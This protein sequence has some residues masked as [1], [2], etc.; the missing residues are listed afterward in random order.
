MTK[1]YRLFNACKDFSIIQLSNYRD[2]NYLAYA[3]FHRKGQC[4][5]LINNQDRELT[6]EVTVWEAGIRKEGVMTT[7]I[8]T[9]QE[10]YSL[11]A[12]EYP[13]QTGRIQIT[14]PAFSGTILKFV[15]EDEAGAP[16]AEPM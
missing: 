4:V 10:G 1:K 7:L 3:R 12:A 9:T 2:Y 8:Q 15:R 11:E 6:K 14:L 16:Q 5:I 13:V